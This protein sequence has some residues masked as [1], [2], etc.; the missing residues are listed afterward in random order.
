MNRW[1]VG[2]PVD[3]YIDKIIS[4]A[5]SEKVKYQLEIEIEGESEANIINLFNNSV[6]KIGVAI[7]GFHSP[8]EKVAINDLMT[9]VLF[10]KSL[11]LDL[12]VM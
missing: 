10:Y 9:L 5:Q 8:Q 3:K 4:L 11:I 7:E 2:E 12:W 6:C 1:P